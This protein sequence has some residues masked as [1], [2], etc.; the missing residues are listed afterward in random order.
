MTVGFYDR[1]EALYI[2]MVDEPEFAENALQQLL[3]NLSKK[4]KE[5]E[6]K[7]LISQRSLLRSHL[8]KIMWN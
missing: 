8:K 1:A 5:M 3:G 7:R 4:Q 6:K 2:I